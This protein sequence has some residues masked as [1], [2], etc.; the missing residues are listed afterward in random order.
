MEWKVVVCC[1]LHLDF[2][3]INVENQ[4]ICYSNYFTFCKLDLHLLETRTMSSGYTDKKRFLWFT[5]DFKVK[6]FEYGYYSPHVTIWREIP[7][8]VMQVWNFRLLVLLRFF[9]YVWEMKIVNIWDVCTRKISRVGLGV[10]CIDFRFIKVE[11]WNDPLWSWN[12]D[13]MILC[14]FSGHHDL[15]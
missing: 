5:R 15:S 1:Y 11:W 2:V 12:S 3:T 8:Y 9:Q 6:Y 4:T 13:L 10:G 14:F 7:M